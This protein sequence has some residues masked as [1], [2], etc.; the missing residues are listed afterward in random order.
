MSI[1]NTIKIVTLG[2]ALLLSAPCA[3]A[4]TN[5][6]MPANQF[7]PNSQYNNQHT[8]PMNTPAPSRLP[9]NAPKQ[10]LGMMNAKQA[11][12]IALQHAGFHEN[13]ISSLRIE[14]EMDDGIMEFEVDFK[15]DGYDYEYIINGNTGQ[16]LSHSFEKRRLNLL[17][18]FKSSNP[19]NL[20]QGDYAVQIALNH[21]GLQQK[22]VVMGEFS[23]DFDDGEHIYEIGFYKN[24]IEYHYEIDAE[25][26]EIYKCEVDYH[27]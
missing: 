18:V 3:F 13:Q 8:V 24:Y 7:T 17:G 26:G 21:A 15:N 10:Q 4:N 22:D 9:V 5:T 19:E 11:K 1:K 23:Y 14:Q 20:I 6:Q 25:T 2:S 12:Q 16:I 27:I